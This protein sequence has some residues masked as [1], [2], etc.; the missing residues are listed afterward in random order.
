[1]KDIAK[2][3]QNTSMEW[4]KRITDIA[5]LL[6]ALIRMRLFGVSTIIDS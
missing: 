3:E 5:K 6:P 2:S 1:M 4:D